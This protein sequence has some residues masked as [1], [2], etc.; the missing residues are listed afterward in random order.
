MPEIDYFSD[1]QLCADG[2]RID[3]L[4]TC[5]PPPPPPPT[6]EKCQDG[7]VVPSLGDCVLC[8]NAL[9]YYTIGPGK[10]CP[11]VKPDLFC[12]N[13]TVNPVADPVTDCLAC[14]DGTKIAKIKKDGTTNACPTP[15]VVP[16][17]V[18][19]GNLNTI[20]CC[21]GT[22][23]PYGGCPLSKPCWTDPMSV[24]CATDTCPPPTT[25]GDG[26][27]VAD[28]AT[29]CH[30][31]PGETH[32]KHISKPCATD[33]AKVICCDGVERAPAD[34]PATQTCPCDGLEICASSSCAIPPATTDYVC[35]NGSTAADCGCSRGVDRSAPV[36]GSCGKSTITLSCRTCIESVCCDGT[37][38]C[39]PLTCPGTKTVTTQTCANGSNQAGC[40]C[41]CPGSVSST[42]TTNDCIINV[43]E[44][45]SCGIP[46]TDNLTV[47]ANGSSAADCG[48]PHGVSSTTSTTVSGC[49]TTNTTTLTCDKPFC[50][51]GF[52]NIAGDCKCINSGPTGG[53]FSGPDQCATPT[54]VWARPAGTNGG[55]DPGC[56][57]TN[58]VNCL[59]G[60]SGW[61]CETGF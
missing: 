14:P 52:T 57:A 60:S 8:T 36:P 42:T 59:G 29:D 37:K 5:A 1:C 20:T 32:S 9:P 46:T 30:T 18:K 16:P 43:S 48:C 38:V 51:P 35:A 25:C 23:A 4:G 19:P 55:N 44:V 34:C 58:P 12:T 49:K 6:V 10:T 28:V 22:T 26:I 40:G 13:D 50:P 53:C 39:A 56:I 54:Q 21:D 17:L 41:A 45:V 61:T 47:C 3:P 2:R 11:V 33:T 15:P 27:R 31:C 24:I 7:T